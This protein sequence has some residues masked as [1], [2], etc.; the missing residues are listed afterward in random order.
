MQL[1]RISKTFKFSKRLKLWKIFPDYIVGSKIIF[2]QEHLP[3]IENLSSSRVYRRLM[4]EKKDLIFRYL[5]PMMG[6]S[7]VSEISFKT[8]FL[9]IR[10]LDVVQN[11]F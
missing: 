3:T 9:T 10:F 11:F 6:C 1:D 8:S 2:G 4:G 7:T 5:S